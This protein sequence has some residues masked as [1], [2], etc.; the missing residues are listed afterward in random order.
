MEF[1]L[2]APIFFSMLLG[3]IEYGFVFYGYSVMQA[4]GNRVARDVAV[5][6]LSINNVQ[7]EFDRIVPGWVQGATVTAIRSNA[8]D[9][10]RSFVQVRVVADA[11]RV[12]PISIF[13]SAFPLTLTADVLVKEELPYGS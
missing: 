11:T 8:V 10:T 12:T 4:G 13:T 3:I 7:A 5:N 1:A 9:P 6:T 2:V